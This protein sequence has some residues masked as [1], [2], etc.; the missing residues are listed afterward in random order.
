MTTIG[1]GNTAPVTQGGR[2]MIFTLG[3]LS[4]LIFAG[5]LA[6]AGSIIVAIVDDW[7]YRI[8]LSWLTWPSI[9]AF[10]WG[11]LYYLWCYAIAW[12]YVYWNQERLDV[13][14]MYKDA[15]WYAYIT[16]T[17]VG[18]GDHYLDHAVLI[19]IDLLVWPLL[20][21]VGFVLLSS[22]LNKVGE[23]LGNLMP[24]EKSSFVET[25]ADDSRPMF[26]CCPNWFQKP[27]SS[28]GMESVSEGTVPGESK[29]PTK[30]EVGELEDKT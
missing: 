5:V 17:T 20:I 18:L 15:Y 13:E 3:F 8:K 2:S 14:I 22:F 12:Y 29:P 7:L 26:S 30:E 25:L 6:K 28:S 11:A 1:Y 23:L 21:L 4:I 10:I 24:A 16:T 19:G 27:Q 9:Q